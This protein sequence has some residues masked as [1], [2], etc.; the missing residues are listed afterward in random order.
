MSRNPGHHWKRVDP[1]DVEAGDKYPEP[2]RVTFTVRQCQWPGFIWF[3]FHCGHGEVIEYPKVLRT[4][5][6]ICRICT[7]TKNTLDKK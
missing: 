5:D 1:D 6:R 3:D 2:Y 7:Q 4:A